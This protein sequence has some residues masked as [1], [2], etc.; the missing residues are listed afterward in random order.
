MQTDRTDPSA[1]LVHEGQVDE[2]VWKVGKVW[3]EVLEHTDRK[4]V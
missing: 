3:H 2:G 1:N 4:L